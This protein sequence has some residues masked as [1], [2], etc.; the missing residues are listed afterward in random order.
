MNLNLTRCPVTWLSAVVIAALGPA[1][2][3]AGRLSS[4]SGSNLTWIVPT[5][6]P[7]L[8]CTRKSIASWPGTCAPTESSVARIEKLAFSLLLRVRN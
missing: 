2:G 7:A 8:F 1:S 3:T 4:D 5:G 6:W